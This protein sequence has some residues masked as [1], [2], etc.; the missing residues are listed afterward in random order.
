MLENNEIWKDCKGYEGLYQ[1]S[2]LGRVW[3]VRKQRIMK[4]ILKKDGYLEITLTAKNGR[5]VYE[6]VHRLVALAFLENPNHFPVVN[7]KDGEKTH[8]EVG[9]L[10]WCS[11]KYNTKHAYD[12]NLGNFQENLQKSTEKAKE[13]NT[14]QYEIWKDG[15]LIAIC[16]GLKETAK[17]ANC[18]EKTVRNCLKAD[19]K[20]R[21]G[22]YYFVCLGGDQRCRT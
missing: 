7:H 2:S 11:V 3:S 18:D 16:Y 17:V 5:S 19:R 14:N 8:N 4:P 20:T 13:V 12:N 22:G 9:N 10:E 1:V 6:R 21:N 15:E